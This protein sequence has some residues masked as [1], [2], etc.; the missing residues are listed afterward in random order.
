MLIIILDVVIFRLLLVLHVKDDVR[1]NKSLFNW[2][3]SFL[4]SS[5]I[6]SSLN[7]KL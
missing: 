6:I 2:Y 4:R 7:K 5:K 1:D 3:I